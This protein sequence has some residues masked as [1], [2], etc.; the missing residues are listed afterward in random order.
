M[1]KGVQRA[2]LAA[3]LFGISAPLAKLLVGDMPPQFLAGLLYL[4]SGLGLLVLRSVRRH[5]V[6]PLE[7]SITRTQV[8]F[9]VGSL[10]AGGILAPVFLMIGLQRTPASGAA[11]LLNL[12][13]VFT[14]LI[15]WLI[16][17]ENLGPRI[18][19][20]MLAIVGGGMLLSWSNGPLVSAE[21]AGPIAVAAACLCWAIDNNLTQKISAADPIQIASWKGL[22][23]G[24]FNVLLALFLGQEPSLGWAVVAALALGFVSYGMSL[25]LYILAMRELGAARAGNYFSFAPFVGAIAGLVL[26]HESLTARL[27][28]GGALMAAGIWLQMT[29][30]HE[31]QHV[32]EP[33]T[34]EHL[35]VHDEHHQHEHG[36]DDPEGEPHSHPHHHDRLEH[37][38]RHYPDTHHQHRH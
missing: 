34:H 3:A 2:L 19:A 16:F 27:S 17:H 20:G 32:H 33:M 4:G 26:F 11:L 22:A 29:E 10:V 14:S 15:A 24:A 37:S 35:H 28:G 21:L 31:H 38:H 36:P 1:N 23:G 18:G 12:E 8:P 13:A 9:F 5:A 7:A 25:V 6:R 30:S